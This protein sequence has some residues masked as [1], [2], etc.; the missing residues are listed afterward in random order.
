VL[1]CVENLCARARETEFIAAQDQRYILT[2]HLV[3]SC[4][5][6]ALLLRDIMHY[7]HVL[8]E[9]PCAAQHHGAW[10]MERQCNCEGETQVPL[11]GLVASNA[12]FHG[13]QVV[14]S[15]GFAVPAT[16]LHAIISAARR[17]VAA[18]AVNPSQA[19]FRA[20]A[21]EALDVNRS[22]L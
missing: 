15:I 18:S 12:A 11:L 10:C 14:P 7:P 4:M 21:L 17:D 13:G 16:E 22:K 6:A 3:S 1:A 5:R 19:G 20:A 9:S 8:Q 2:A